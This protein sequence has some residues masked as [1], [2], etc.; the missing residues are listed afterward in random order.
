MLADLHTHTNASD[1]KLSPD[2]LL[3][4]AA[5]A[6]VDL[7]AITDH[8]TVAG[9]QSL[10][11]RESGDCKLIHGI[12][13]STTWRKIAIHVVGLNINMNN[14]ILLAG[15]SRQQ[16]ARHARAGII[17]ERLE[18]LGYTGVYEGAAKLAGAGGI[19]RPH[20]AQYL[21]DSGQI[22]SVAE[23]FRK[24]LGPGKPGDVKES[25]ASLDEVL[26]WIHAAKG[27][28]V[29]AHPAKY[30]LSNLKLEEMAKDFAAAGGDALEVVSGRQERSITRRLGKLANRCE[31][32]ASAGSD[33][34]RP[35]KYWA[36]LGEVEKL[37]VDC[38]P[39]WQNW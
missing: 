10:T 7:L 27:S 37:P 24:H 2:K 19:A 25:W 1:G 36:A 11:P 21:E 34:H 5:A 12:E 9:L 14:P 17:A 29:L 30:K 22:K 8:D 35:S 18:K 16:E 38:T 31:L 33:F 13:L 39:V 4:D 28:A 20:F 15:I 32:L 3:Q 6:G 23:A 26:E